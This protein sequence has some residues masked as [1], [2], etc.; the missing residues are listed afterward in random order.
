MKS[1]VTGVARRS[2]RPRG[3]ATPHAAPQAAR[4]HANCGMLH[5]MQL[6]AL[7]PGGRGVPAPV[8]VEVDARPPAQPPHQVI[9][10][11]V[12][13]R[14]AV[15]LAPQVDEHIVRVQIPVLAVQ[16]VGI[17]PDQ[18]GADRDRPRLTRLAA[19]PVVVVPGHHR[20]LALG[21]G[22]VLMPQ[23]QRLADPAC[24]SHT[25]AANS[26]RSRSRSQASRIAC[27]SATVEHPRQL[28]RR[29]QRDRPP[30]LRLALA[31]VVQKRLPRRAPP[32]GGLPGD[33]QLTQIDPA[34]APRAGRTR[35]TPR[36]CG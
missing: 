22:Q 19:G 23:A 6:R 29:L 13:Q 35:S 28:A 34:A 30:G 14:V 1:Q 31:D 25:A 18:P 32:P 15:R 3:T 36:A 26:N 10:R 9:D 8:R 2:G 5:L 4:V 17:Q 27:I 24:R 12:G 16:V 11:R 21:G 20:H 33:Q 7:H